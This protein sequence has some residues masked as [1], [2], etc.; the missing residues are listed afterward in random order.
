MQGNS[1]KA[2]YFSGLGTRS[3]SLRTEKLKVLCT[4]GEPIAIPTENRFSNERTH[5]TARL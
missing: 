3:G 1:A 4:I 2:F 5:Y